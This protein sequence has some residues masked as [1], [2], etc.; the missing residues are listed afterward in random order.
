M[1]TVADFWRELAVDSKWTVDNKLH[2]HVSGE[3]V[4]TRFG[5]TKVLYSFTRADGTT[6]TNGAMSRPKAADV[7]VE[8]DRVHFLLGDDIAFT[9]IKREGT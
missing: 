9:W 7:R 4:I 5:P 1:R 8:A 6:G 3:R 2:P